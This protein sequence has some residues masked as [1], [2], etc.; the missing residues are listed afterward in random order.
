METD[1]TTTDTAF[2]IRVTGEF[3]KVLGTGEWSPGIELTIDE[4][5][6]ATLTTAERHSSEGNSRTFDVAHGRTL[7]YRA[8]LSQGSAAIADPDKMEALAEKL[9]PLAARIAAGHEVDWD[10]NNNVGKLVT[11][12]ACE[13]DEELARLFDEIDASDWSKE[14]AV[15][16]VG[17]WLVD[18]PEGITHK[19]TEDELDAMV[20]E[21]EGDAKADDVVLTGDIL[22]RLKE[23]RDEAVDAKA[24]EVDCDALADQLLAEWEALDE[25]ER[26]E[27]PNYADDRLPMP[28][29]LEDDLTVVLGNLQDTHWGASEVDRDAI[30]STI[31]GL[32]DLWK[33]QQ[34]G[35]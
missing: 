26:A 29:G 6:D 2:D 8:L 4:D 11:E 34:K 7:L 16:E 31:D 19:T 35:R 24:E 17:E 10:G 28:I 33:D 15:W 23:F 21:I 20:E 5:G 30:S 27:L 12:D 22:E 9:A 32:L 14:I 13:A 18:C 25:E 3:R 1:M